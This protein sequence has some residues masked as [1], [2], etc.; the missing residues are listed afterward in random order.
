MATLTE[1][2]DKFP[3]ATRSSIA[4][5]IP[6]I[7][8]DCLVEN[9][10]SNQVDRE[11]MSSIAAAC[12]NWGF[13]QVIN[14]GISEQLLDKTFQQSQAFFASAQDDKDRLLRSYENP[15][16]YYNNEL[17]KNQRDKK[18]V[19]DFTAKGVDPI[20][21]SQNRWPSHIPDF[22]QIMMSYFDA[23][24]DLSLLL[25]EA[26]CLG[27]GLQPRHLHDHVVGNHTGFTR[28]NYYPVKDPMTNS[29]LPHQPLADLGVHHHTDAGVLTLLAQDQV[30]GLQV[31]KNELWHPVSSIPGAIVVNTG[32]MM[33]VWSNDQYQAAMHRV[34]A[35]ERI[36]RYSIPFFF[37]PSADSVVQPLPISQVESSPI[38]YRPINWNQ[39]RGGRTAGDYADYG[40]EVQISHFR[41]ES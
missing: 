28:L 35:M 4:E 36:D 15:W 1:D 16:G 25:L 34:V 38:R 13:F 26:F 21:Q 3:V 31:F 10:S 9:N 23:C 17:T 11:V 19:F 29:G 39:Y 37:N 6:V 22:Q 41:V 20:Y 5:Q 27:L 24:T 33:Q 8:I 2:L 32:D 18:E 12:E 30:G 40:T 7:D 14:H